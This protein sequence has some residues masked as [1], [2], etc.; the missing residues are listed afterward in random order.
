MGLPAG[1]RKATNPEGV[2]YYFNKGQNISQYE[3]PSGDIYGLY[4]EIH[5][6]PT[7]PADKKIRP[8]H[9]HL[10][11]TNDVEI[12]TEN[13]LN[14][15]FSMTENPLNRGSTMTENQ[16]DRGSTM[17]ENPLNRASTM[18]ENPLNRGSTI[19]E[20]PLDS[21]SKRNKGEGFKQTL[22]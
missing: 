20:N 19:T 22:V 18:T 16:L 5:E 11:D 17:T 10:M 2:T 14:R 3:Y 15:G 8:M 13:P 9:V 7:N 4:P 21:I 1:W 12:M 6:Q